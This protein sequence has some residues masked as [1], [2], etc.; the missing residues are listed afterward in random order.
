MDGDPGK[1][2]SHLLPFEQRD[3]H[4]EHHHPGL[5]PRDERRCVISMAENGTPA[6]G[7]GY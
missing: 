2:N 6:E 5:E 4:I 3:G 7:D 1:T